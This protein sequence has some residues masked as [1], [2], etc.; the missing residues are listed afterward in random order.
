MPGFFVYCV[1]RNLKITV[2]EFTYDT[3]RTEILPLT[4]IQ[5]AGLRRRKG[6]RKSLI[7]KRRLL[8]FSVAIKIY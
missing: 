3:G 4:D 6:W 8:A 1:M 2:W 7:T 5:L